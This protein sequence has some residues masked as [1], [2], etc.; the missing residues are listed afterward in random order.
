MT[1]ALFTSAVYPSDSH[2]IAGPAQSEKRT[3]PE[4]AD[5]DGVRPRHK[6]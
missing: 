5:P 3:V 1:A 4:V 2:S 6:R